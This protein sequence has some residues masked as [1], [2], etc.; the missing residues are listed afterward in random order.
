MFSCYLKYASCYDKVFSATI[1]HLKGIFN[2]TYDAELL[3]NM[4]LLTNNLFLI[5]PKVRH[6]PKLL[7]LIIV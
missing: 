2:K 4:K 1:Q 5:N 6:N 3:S 7:F